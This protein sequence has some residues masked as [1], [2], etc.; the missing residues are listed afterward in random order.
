MNCSASVL[1]LA[2]DGALGVIQ[3][4]IRAAHKPTSQQLMLS[5]GA[6]GLSLLL[7]VLIATGELV[8]VYE[9]MHRHPEVLW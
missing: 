2:M 5:I 1:S 6:W 3:D 9:F 4:K 7:I 8:Q